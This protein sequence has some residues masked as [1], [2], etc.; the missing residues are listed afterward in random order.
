M[1][2]GKKSTKRRPGDEKA[3]QAKENQHGKPTTCQVQLTI[4]GCLSQNKPHRNHPL[5]PILED[6]SAVDTNKQS[7]VK[8]VDELNAPKQE[9]T[10]KILKCAHNDQIDAPQKDSGTS[11]QTKS[12]H[13][14]NGEKSTDRKLKGK[15]SE[16]NRK[17]TDY[18]PIRRSCR[19]SKAELKC[20]KQQHID[21]L[22]RNDV[23]EGLKVKCIEGK[24]RGIFAD[25]AF[26]KGEFVVEYHGDLLEIADAKARESQ[27]A[28]DPSTGCYMYYF[29]YHDKT[30]C[31]DAT[32]ET[33]RLGRL[34]NHSKNGNL[35]TKLHAINGTP[36][37]IFLASRDLE[38]D[39]ELLYDYGDRSKEALAAHPWLKH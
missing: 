4:N 33:H 21:D 9:N 32:K 37:L 23:E 25:R 22:I 3:E 17:V 38:E 39:E 26:K 6:N 27:Y 35:Q 34:I 12:G 14:M 11:K 7:E 1:G 18:Y 10:G 24:G 5:I 30:Y 16:L 19:K 2:K 28:Q 15:E 8:D 13:R 31:V 20:E 36:H 29:R